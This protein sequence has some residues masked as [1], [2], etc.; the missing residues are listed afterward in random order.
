MPDV[1]G[2]LFYTDTLPPQ[3]CV[4]DALRLEALGYDAVWL[5]DLFGRELFVTA[6]YLLAATTRLRVASG[7]ANVYARDATSAAQAARTLSELYDGRFILG[8]GVSHP[9]AAS[10]RGHRWEP[11]VEKLGAYL[12]GIAS[13]SVNAPEPPSTAPIFIAAHGPR[14]LALAAERADG[15]NTY[16]MPPEHTRQ[17]RDIL[18]PDKQLNVVLPCC[19]C[20]DATVARGVAR[21]G[22]SMYLQLPAYQRQW[23]RFGLEER[24]RGDGGSDRLIDTL[25]AWGDECAIRTRIAAHIEAG[26]NRI[27]VLP[28]NAAPKTRERPWDLLE[29]LAPGTH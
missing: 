3:D 15:A 29:A 16:L 8:L 11:P 25:V 17:A 4:A 23:A 26:A 19:L 14:L 20:A 24:D 18:G 13:A 6:G 27:I 22:L 7:I 12:E 1:D 2:V 10:A 28:Y 5:P 9:Q 21:M